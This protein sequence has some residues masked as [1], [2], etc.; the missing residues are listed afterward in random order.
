MAVMTAADLLVALGADASLAGRVSSIHAACTA[1]VERYAPGA[2][3][4]VKTEALVLYAAW[5]YQ[6]QAQRRSV[7]PADG[8]PPINVSRAFLLSGAQALLTSW[9]V[10]RAGASVLP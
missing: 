1:R 2:P 3:D 7:F 6:S 4:A 5:V 9:R 10:P 8:D